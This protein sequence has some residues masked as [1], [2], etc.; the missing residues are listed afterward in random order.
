MLLSLRSSA[1]LTEDAEG[2]CKIESSRG[3]LNLQVPTPGSRQA[4]RTLAS[5]PATEDELAEQVLTADGSAALTVFYYYLEHLRAHGMLSCS[6]PAAG[7]LLLTLEPISPAF[8]WDVPEVDVDRQFV[9]SRF[10]FSRRLATSLVL[11]SPLAPARA[12]LHGAAGAS[13]LAALAQACSSRGLVDC[14][15]G[16]DLESSR[17]ALSVLA[18]SGLVCEARAGGSSEEDENEALV[19]WEFH[20]LLFH[21]RSRPGRHDSPTGATYRFLGRI[22]PSPALKPAMSEDLIQL[23]RPD[24]ARIIEHDEPFTQVVERRLSLRDHGQPPITAAQV[25][26]FLY[27]TARVRSVGEPGSGSRRPYATSN[28]P[29]PGNGAA[30]ELE[31]YLTIAECDGIGGGLYHYEPLDHCLSKVS[32]VTSQTEALLRSAAGASGM[33]G[34]SQILITLT[35]RFQRLSWKYESIAYAA[36][37]KDV[38]VLCQTMYLVATAMGLAPCALGS[39]DSDLFAQATGLSYLVESS[40][41]EFALGSR[42]L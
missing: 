3:T 15:A 39:G 1:V 13:L 23:R 28:R 33:H 2:R 42:R 24:L 6:V 32:V 30:Y 4:L 17:Q 27:R 9:L 41:G 34:R 5:H 25:G 21:A 8:R 7:G 31:I 20:D 22:P 35:A 38:G 29:Y 19:Q 26:E 40:V 18:G 11:E 12:V 10:A 36:V 14:I 37:L 16:A